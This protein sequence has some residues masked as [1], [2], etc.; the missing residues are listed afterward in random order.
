MAAEEEAPASTQKRRINMVGWFC[1]HGSGVRADVAQ[2][3]A[4]RERL[5][6]GALVRDDSTSRRPMLQSFL[7]RDAILPCPPKV[8]FQRT[9]MQHRSATPNASSNGPFRWMS[10]LGKSGLL[11]CAYSARPVRVVLELHLQYRVL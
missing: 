2:W 8:V 6:K 7:S 1:V 4:Q 3:V 11:T 10:P 5:P 9:G